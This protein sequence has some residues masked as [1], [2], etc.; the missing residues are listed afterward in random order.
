[1]SPPTAVF[2]ISKAVT[3]WKAQDITRTFDQSPADEDRAVSLTASLRLNWRA[4]KFLYGGRCFDTAKII[5]Q[6]WDINLQ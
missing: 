3:L 4:M 1:M 2:M 6:L 5:A